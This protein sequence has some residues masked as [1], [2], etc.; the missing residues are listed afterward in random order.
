MK[1]MLSKNRLLATLLSIVMLCSVLPAG[2]FAYINAESLCEDEVPNVG[3]A[4]HAE[5]VTLA[6]GMSETAERTADGD[7]P[8]LTFNNMSDMDGIELADRAHVREHGLYVSWDSALFPGSGPINGA[9][10]GFWDFQLMMRMQDPRTGQWRSLTGHWE[11]DM[12][13]VNGAWAPRNLGQFEPQPAMYRRPLRATFLT[14]RDAN[15]GGGRLGA[16]LRSSLSHADPNGWGVTID[17]GFSTQQLN[18]AGGMARLVDPQGRYLWDV[19]IGGGDSPLSGR[20]VMDGGSPASI[21]SSSNA[22]TVHNATHQ[23]LDSG[24]GILFG[25]DTIFDGTRNST[26]NPTGTAGNYNWGF[27]YLHGRAGMIPD[28]RVGR[29]SRTGSARAGRA[30]GWT[31]W[32]MV[33][34]ERGGNALP[35]PNRFWDSVPYG[36]TGT[37]LM[38]PSR[39]NPGHIANVSGTVSNDGH[40]NDTAFRGT[41]WGRFLTGTAPGAVTTGWDG[42]GQNTSADG[43]FSIDGT[44]GVNWTPGTGGTAASVA[45][46]AGRRPAVRTAG[47]YQ[48]N[49]YM[50]TFRNTAHWI[51]RETASSGAQMSYRLGINAMYH[52]AQTTRWTSVYGFSAFDWAPPEADDYQVRAFED[53][54]FVDLTLYAADSGTT[55]EG[56]VTATDIRSRNADGTPNMVSE[57]WTETVT[58]GIR[59]YFVMV[60]QSPTGMPT[61]P[62]VA[63]TG[64]TAGNILFQNTAATGTMWFPHVDGEGAEFRHTFPG[65]GNMQNTYLHMV[66]VDNAGNIGEVLSIALRELAVS[67]EVIVLCPDGI[68][69]QPGMNVTVEG[70]AGTWIT[71]EN[72]RVTISHSGFTLGETYAIIVRDPRV[73]TE[74]SLVP[75]WS[76]GAGS[77]YISL[78]NLSP[79]VEILM[80]DPG[81]GTIYGWVVDSVTGEPVSNAVVRIPG[82]DR[83]KITNDRGFYVFMNVPAPR[84]YHMYVSQVDEFNLQAAMVAG[85]VTPVGVVPGGTHRQDFFLVPESVELTALSGGFVWECECP[86]SDSNDCDTYVTDFEDA[87]YGAVPIQRAVISIVGPSGPHHVVTDDTGWWFSRPL[88]R[89]SDYVITATRAGFITR[90]VNVHVPIEAKQHYMHFSMVPNWPG[91]LHIRVQDPSGMPLDN[92]DVIVFSLDRREVTGTQVN[93]YNDLSFGEA[94][95]T[96]VPVSAAGDPPITYFFAVLP[97]LGTNYAIATGIITLGAEDRMLGEYKF[98]DEFDG[99]IPIHEGDRMPRNSIT[100]QLDYRPTDVLHQSLVYGRVIEAVDRTTGIVGGD[101]WA[102][103]IYSATD[104]P[105]FASNHAAVSGANGYYYLILNFP[106]TTTNQRLSLVAEAVGY[107]HDSAIVPFIF[108]DFTR[109]DFYLDRNTNHPN[110]FTNPP[111]SIIFG[112]V[113]GQIGVAPGWDLRAGALVE[114]LNDS[115]SAFADSLGFYVITGISP[116]EFEFMASQ[117]MF[118]PDQDEIVVGISDNRVRQD[119]LLRNTVNIIVRALDAENPGRVVHHVTL[120]AIS[121]NQLNA[122]NFRVD[123]PFTLGDY[124]LVPLTTGAEGWQYVD[125]IRRDPSIPV[126]FMIR[127]L[128]TPV[129]IRGIYADGT[130]YEGLPV[131]TIMVRRGTTFNIDSV[132]A[133]GIDT[134]VIDHALLGF[135]NPDDLC[136][137]YGTGTCDC[138]GSFVV[139]FPNE[140]H[141]TF[142]IRYARNRGQLNVRAMLF[143]E[144]QILDDETVSGTLA[145]L[146]VTVELGDVVRVTSGPNGWVYINGEPIARGLYDAATL[147]FTRAA[148]IYPNVEG[149]TFEGGEAYIEFTFNGIGQPS[150][151]EFSYLRMRAP[152]I[153]ELIDMTTGLPIDFTPTRLTEMVY[154]EYTSEDEERYVQEWCDEARDYIYVYD[155]SLERTIRRGILY[156]V[157]APTHADGLPLHYTLVSTSS[158]EISIFRAGEEEYVF[159]RFFF[160]RDLGQSV[161]ARH[162]FRVWDWAGDGG[163]TEQL[164]TQD[165]ITG[166]VG[167]EVS[168]SAREDLIGWR[169]IE[170]RIGDG[171]LSDN[172]MVD[173]TINDGIQYVTFIYE[174]QMVQVT[175][176][177]ILPGEDDEYTTLYSW[178]KEVLPN[179]GDL[180]FS[181]THIFDFA[182]VSV[183]AEEWE[184]VVIYESDLGNWHW[185]QAS[186]TPPPYAVNGSEITVTPG[187]R[188]LLVT[189]VYRSLATTV[190]VRAYEVDVEMVSGNPVYSN[191]QAITPFP[192][193]IPATESRPFQFHAPAINGFDFVHSPTGNNIAET[194]RTGGELIFYYVRSVGDVTVRAVEVDADGEW[195]RDI[196]TFTHRI[197]HGE[198]LT[199]NPAPIE[200][201]GTD[202]YTLYAGES[203]A[204][205]VFTSIDTPDEITIRYVR[206]TRN[207]T[208]IAMI[209]GTTTELGRTQSSVLRVGDFAEINGA[210]VFGS[211]FEFN[212]PH[213]RENFRLLPPNSQSLLVTDEANLSVTF[214][215]EPTEQVEFTV[216]LRGRQAGS[217]TQLIQTLTFMGT[218]GTTVTINAPELSGWENPSPLYHTIEIPIEGTVTARVFLYDQVDVPVIPE[219]EVTI[220]GRAL[221]FGKTRSNVYNAAGAVVWDFE[222]NRYYI[223]L[224]ILVELVNTVTG[225]VIHSD[226]TFEADSTAGANNFELTF[227]ANAEIVALLQSNGGAMLRFTR[228]GEEL[229]YRNRTGTTQEVYVDD[230]YLVTEV[231]F[232][233]AGAVVEDGSVISMTRSVVLYAGAFFEV[234]RVDLRDVSI[235]RTLIGN[236]D[237]DFGRFNINEYWGVNAGDLNSVSRSMGGHDRNAAPARASYA[238]TV[239]P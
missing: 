155:Y 185:Y 126:D 203:T 159:V 163:Y 141:N 2:A 237:P 173:I 32:G 88:S 167:D 153:I 224:G 112:E 111:T 1:N 68:A 199:I 87:P 78:D 142:Y 143:F 154:N 90:V 122:H 51:M 178:H 210:T 60:N 55:Y 166:R 115:M 99:Y 174:Q 191:R 211:T 193:A 150:D 15:V 216:E 70:L 236:T 52:V 223:D 176:R 29:I 228:R 133:E 114:S 21:Q 12:V 156:D 229:V 62:R 234:D 124:E 144:D 184:E 63:G 96:D 117:A 38:Y 28:N 91:A 34:S 201:L 26:S 219:I 16:D 195:L 212:A 9:D 25:G 44:R 56:Y 61:V 148:D 93:D 66:A 179:S 125:L 121:T 23:F 77:V 127:T 190:N 30:Y 20:R 33:G 92:A 109:Q 98:Y 214:Y 40:L 113:R 230:M 205:R 45:T 11:D 75:P 175:V 59:G 197:A 123:Q 183:S 118:A 76:P 101:V 188:S 42:N 170:S 220:E 58:S 162:V 131:H 71:D 39:V 198:T 48:S 3:I 94:I 102:P 24:R 235:L 204:N 74:D 5:A 160:I 104:A 119:F 72:G 171:A 65:G 152:L 69:P 73:I 182:F 200:L 8:L 135:G 187:E 46:G 108:G 37:V 165:V 202:I 157:A 231:R 105:W 49:A 164:I 222:A 181:S 110:E 177:G 221:L 227:N 217:E 213:L 130:E 57:R 146:P 103:A 50:H 79:S 14:P 128:L 43:G 80:G 136:V 129:T 232:D 97:P 215:F 149:Y 19:L 207:I 53:L 27:S 18:A 134:N 233:G 137:N 36:P 116:G 196:Q 4:A 226:M 67:V 132:I 13:W 147:L 106:P 206:R 186:D 168:V 120:P 54:G 218:R 172:A 194:P 81:T 64:I 83:Y 208:V 85:T 151:V 139:G 138:D 180:T 145:E 17:N 95:F 169:F 225:E 10:G 239:T 189:F 47:L 89:G 41:I 161:I 100:V 209:D 86:S 84:N 31:P 35:Q 140:V 158:Q 22:V 107:N 192:L 82:L 238:F 7:F 6:D